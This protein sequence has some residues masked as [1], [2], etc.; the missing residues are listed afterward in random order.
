MLLWRVFKAGTQP[1]TVNVVTSRSKVEGVAYDVRMFAP[2]VGVP[3]DPVCG[4]AN[5]I[6]A[7]YWAHK[8]G[9]GPENVGENSREMMARHVSKRGGQFWTEV[10]WSKGK[11]FVRGEARLTTRGVVTI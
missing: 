6:N 11:V 2:V 4:S 3:E 1:R 8:Y 5:C 9:L 10:D 7:P